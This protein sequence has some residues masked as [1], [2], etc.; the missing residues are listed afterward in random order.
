MLEATRVSKLTYAYQCAKEFVLLRGY[1][2]EVAWQQNLH[3]ENI[4][5]SSFLREA[6]WVVLS[7]GMRETV[8]RRCFPSI[9]AA[10]L[11][12]ASAA[13]ISAQKTTCVRTALVH[14]NHAKKIAAIADIASQVDQMGFKPVKERIHEEGVLFLQ[15][16]PY[17]G[18]VTSY[19]LAKNLGL[20]VVKPDR[21]LVRIAE[22][23]GYG[24]P[25]AMCL[26]LSM[27]VGERLA[28]IDIIMWR[29]ATLDPSYLDLFTTL[30]PP[31]R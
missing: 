12:W 29:Y 22:A 27:V 20:D 14:F 17:I 5:E 11:N 24:S 23:L 21:H 18:P 31:G 30:N 6:A 26:D 19:H 28:V 9:E 10:F 2:K 13:V 3:L 15:Q 25:E 8:V 4:S 16:F 1:E 7:G